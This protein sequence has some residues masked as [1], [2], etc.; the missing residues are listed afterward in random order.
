MM[1]LPRQTKNQGRL[2]TISGSVPR[3]LQKE[4]GCRF[5]NRC[6]YALERCASERPDEISV[7]ETHK[8]RCFLTEFLTD[9]G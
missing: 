9:K 2:Q 6:P 4:I 7:S 1:A 3:I 5:A 8:Y